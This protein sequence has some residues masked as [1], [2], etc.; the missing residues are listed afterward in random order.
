MAGVALVIA[1]AGAAAPGVAAAAGAYGAAEVA[2][3]TLAS[4]A[5]TAAVVSAVSGAAYLATPGGSGAMSSASMAALGAG[6][7]GAIALAGPPGLATAGG[8]PFSMGGRLGALTAGALA[9]PSPIGEALLGTALA[10]ILL[11]QGASAL[12][13]TLDDAFYRDNGVIS[14]YSTKRVTAETILANRSFR[15][16]EFNPANRGGPYLHTNNTPFGARTEARYKE[17]VL[18]VYAT[19]RKL[20]RLPFP[21]PYTYG[22]N[23]MISIGAQTFGFDA[24]SFPSTKVPGTINY[25]FFRYEGAIPIAEVQ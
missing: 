15:Y 24:M 18:Q 6:G 23:Q 7:A 20:L 12:R 14:Y 16:A 21:P 3:G 22:L 1:T 5:T 17:A 9:E 13:Q 19:P 10:S 25:V 8:A 11:Y 2:A 4:W